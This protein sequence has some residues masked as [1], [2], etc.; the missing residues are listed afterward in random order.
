MP[1]IQTNNNKMSKISI[2]AVVHKV[3]DVTLHH[4]LSEIFVQLQGTKY[5]TFYTPYFLELANF[6]ASVYSK[7]VLDRCMHRFTYL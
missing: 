7:A 2:M 1:S 3:S 6:L 5:E 4:P